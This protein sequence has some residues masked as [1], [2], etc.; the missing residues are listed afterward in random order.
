MS[1][2]LGQRA[3]LFEEIPPKPAPAAGR[4]GRRWQ[5]IQRVPRTLRC[6]AHKLHV[7]GYR[8][9]SLTSLPTFHEVPAHLAPEVPI[10]SLCHEQVFVARHRVLEQPVRQD[11]VGP[12]DLSESTDRIEYGAAAVDDYFQLELV[13]IFADRARAWNRSHFS[14]M[15][16]AS[17]N[18]SKKRTSFVR[19]WMNT[20]DQ[21]WPSAGTA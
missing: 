17:M 2:L 1:N 4:Q 19:I 7:R 11:Y 15:I 13:H 3:E 16:M 20:S 6:V 12:R 8:L 10:R 5:R 9:E 14:P 18:T 21:S